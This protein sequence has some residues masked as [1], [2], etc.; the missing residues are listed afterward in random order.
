MQT[1]FFHCP[2]SVWEC[3]EERI[4]RRHRPSRFQFPFSQSGAAR[5]IRWKCAI[6]SAADKALSDPL[7][8]RLSIVLAHLYIN[9]LAGWLAI[10][11]VAGG[12]AVL[13]YGGLWAMVGI[14]FVLL[15]V[16]AWSRMALLGRVLGAIDD[17]AQRIAMGESAVRIGEVPRSVRI[18]GLV[19][20]FNRMAEALDAGAQRRHIA[21]AGVSH[22][23]RTPLTILK[24]RLHA[25]EDGIIGMDVTETRNLL[26]QVAHILRIVD[27]FDMLGKTDGDA[28]PLNLEIVDL[29]QIIAPAVGD[30]EPL[31]ERHG[32]TIS[33]ATQRTMVVGD[34]VRLMQ[35]VTN[36]VTN[37]A[38]HSQP[39]ADVKVS[40]QA[41]EGRAIICVTDAG[42]GFPEEDRDRLFQ[43]FWRSVEDRRKGCPGSGIGLTL[44]AAL[45]RAHGGELS[46]ENRDDRSGARFSVLLPLA[47]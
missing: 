15:V 3:A 43:P 10:L 14:G 37:A 19:E 6:F 21:A 38:K 17:A 25:M 40:V 1:S 29:A 47:A 27:D 20:R 9:P 42:A 12:F 33:Q 26:R 41:R 31:V 34:P 44:T 18:G 39:G 35:I 22:E 16:F 24:G 30:L 36:L 2:E 45:V 8:G 23:I 11:F 13:S 5:M 46:A 28:L 32:L 7:F 4:S